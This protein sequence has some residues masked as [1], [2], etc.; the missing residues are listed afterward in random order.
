MNDSC[1]KDQ[2]PRFRLHV[3]RARGYLRGRA[4][5]VVKIISDEGIPRG[6]HIV[7][8]VLACPG[9]EQGPLRAKYARVELYR[10]LRCEGN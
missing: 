10:T 5:G 8:F 3:I 1:S 6:R 9:F 7:S 2:P 4:H